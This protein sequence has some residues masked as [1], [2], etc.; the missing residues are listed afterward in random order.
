MSSPMFDPRLNFT[1][2]EPPAFAEFNRPLSIGLLNDQPGRYTLYVRLTEL[3]LPATSSAVTVNVCVPAVAV[4][5][6]LPDGTGP[7]QDARPEATSE[8][9]YDAAGLEP[10]A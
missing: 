8:H 1:G 5:N 10:R 2:I 4:S 9:E 6:G 3:L 7:A